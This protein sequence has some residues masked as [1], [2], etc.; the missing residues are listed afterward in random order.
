MLSSTPDVLGVYSAPSLVLNHIFAFL[1]ILERDAKET[2]TS[3]FVGTFRNSK[4]TNLLRSTACYFH[5]I[6]I[7]GAIRNILAGG[8]GED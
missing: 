6:L 3:P 5:H 7:I 1:S 8:R 4:P 2:L